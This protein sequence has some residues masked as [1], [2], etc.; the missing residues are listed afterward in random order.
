MTRIH[1]SAICTRDMEGSLRFWRDGLGFVVQM[2]ERFEGDWPALFGA[3]TDHLHSVF[4]GHPGDLEGGIVELVEFAGM[5][6]GDP[7]AA[8]PRPGFFLLS[9]YADLDATVARLAE[10]GLGGEPR[11]IEVAGGVQMGVVRD[12]NGV[13]VE[14]IDPRARGNLDRMTSAP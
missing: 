8:A 7:G 5:P 4:L 3:A 12:P 10:L 6:E 13:L 1:H 9:L 14:L 11:R 2:D